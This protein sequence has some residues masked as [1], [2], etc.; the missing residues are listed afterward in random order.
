MSTITVSMQRK[1]CLG[2]EITFKIMIYHFK[3]II[4]YATQLKILTYNMTKDIRQQIK[5][6]YNSC[7]IVAR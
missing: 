3:F 2:T 1:G 7:T 4:Q 6:L 5:A